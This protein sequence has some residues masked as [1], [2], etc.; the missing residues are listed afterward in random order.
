MREREW[1][2][3]RMNPETLPANG[4]SPISIFHPM[5]SHSSAAPYLRAGLFVAEE[6]DLTAPS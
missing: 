1:H 3:V 5:T 6:P 2:G 4:P